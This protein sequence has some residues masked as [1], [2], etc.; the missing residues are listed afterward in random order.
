MVVAVV[1]LAAAIAVAVAESIS[2]GSAF[3]KLCALRS[4]LVG[5]SELH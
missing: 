4:S 1:A 5:R 3:S 2:L